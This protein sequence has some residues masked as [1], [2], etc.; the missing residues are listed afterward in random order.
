MTNVNKN[1]E[2]QNDFLSE[3]CGRKGWIF[4]FVQFLDLLSQKNG[5]FPFFFIFDFAS[6]IGLKVECIWGPGLLLG[7][8]NGLTG[9]WNLA[10]RL[11]WAASWAFRRNGPGGA[12]AGAG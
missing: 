3:K 6:R 11:G 10:E 2:E 5:I 9:G 12:P 1:R 7:R 8:T 4:G